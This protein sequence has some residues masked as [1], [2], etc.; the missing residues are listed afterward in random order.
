LLWLLPHG[1]RIGPSRTCW[2]Q[3]GNWLFRRDTQW[4]RKSHCNREVV[5]SGGLAAGFTQSHDSDQTTCSS[6]LNKYSQLVWCVKIPC[7]NP[8]LACD[9]RAVSV[10]EPLVSRY[11]WRQW[12]VHTVTIVKTAEEFIVLH[13]LCLNMTIGP[14]P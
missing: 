10:A 7:R 12:F 4:V 13:L 2:R 8:G 6:V 9:V 11:R 5:L 14:L 3:S 1:P